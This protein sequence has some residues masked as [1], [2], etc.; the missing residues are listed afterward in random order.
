M[1]PR[2]I[3]IFQDANGERE[4]WNVPLTERCSRKRYGHD[5]QWPYA[6]VYHIE[7]PENYGY[8]SIDFLVCDWNVQRAP[9]KNKAQ[10]SASGK[11]RDNA[12]HLK[13]TAYGLTSL[14][15]NISE[16]VYIRPLD[17]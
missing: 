10:G 16:K 5:M 7:G 9:A 4:Q 12:C 1:V 13:V 2:P 11:A 6:L 8:T 14:A 17:L 3:P 15:Q